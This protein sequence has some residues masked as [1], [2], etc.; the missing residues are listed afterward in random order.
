MLTNVKFAKENVVFIKACTIV[1]QNLPDYKT[2]RPTTRQA[3]KFRMRKGIAYRN[4]IG[5]LPK[6]VRT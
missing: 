3:S 5:D 4:Y 2:F 6:E 1:Q